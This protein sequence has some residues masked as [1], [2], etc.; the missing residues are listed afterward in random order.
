MLLSWSLE[1][2]PPSAAPSAS[3]CPNIASQHL[4]WFPASLSPHGFCPWKKRA[5]ARLAGPSAN[6]DI[7]SSAALLGRRHR[8]TRCHWRGRSGSRG[9]ARGASQLPIPQPGSKIPPGNPPCAPPGPWLPLP[10]WKED[11]RD[12]GAEPESPSGVTPPCLR[13]HVGTEQ[14]SL[15]A[16][17]RPTRAILPQPRRPRRERREQ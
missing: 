3:N 11:Q 14:V 1:A 9:T 7:P 10:A 4:T 5:W 8:R 12:V 6:P 13:K 17:G 15:H 2:L 16:R